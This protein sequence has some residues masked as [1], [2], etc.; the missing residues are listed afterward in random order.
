MK[1]AVVILSAGMSSRMGIFK[2]LMMLGDKTFLDNQID[3]FE[4]IEVTNIIVVTGNHSD[5]VKEALGNRNVTFAYNPDYANGEMY[6]STLI[7]LKEAVNTGA[8]KILFTTADVPLF[9]ISDVR[10]LILSDSDVAYLSH[11]Y[12][13]GHPIMM[14]LATAK[15]ILELGEVK[16][17]L[18]QALSQCAPNIDYIETDDEG[19]LMDADTIEDYERLKGY[20]EDNRERYMEE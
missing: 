19:C 15:R 20:F 17:G 13:K 11:D 6:L 7:G 18:K 14:S 2:P 9:T 16:N 1:T 12:K 4:K 5:E 10:K 8:D 3:R